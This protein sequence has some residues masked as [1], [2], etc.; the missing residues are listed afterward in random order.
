MVDLVDGRAIS[1]TERDRRQ[2]ACAS[3]DHWLG[4]S[5]QTTVHDVLQIGPGPVSRMLAMCGQ[6][7]YESGGAVSHL[8]YTILAIVDLR[9]DYKRALHRAW[10]AVALWKQLQPVRS[11]RPMPRTMML[12]MVALSLLWGWS[13]IAFG[14]AVGFSAMLR[15]TE[16]MALKAQNIVAPHELGAKGDFV[17]VQIVSPKMR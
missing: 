14:I 11:H 5:M 6:W 10:D 15:R 8:T 7:L 4:Q 9:R 12:A 3:F 17:F 13:D 2:H 1:Q 16:I